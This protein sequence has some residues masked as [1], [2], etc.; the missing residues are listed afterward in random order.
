M[1]VE[2]QMERLNALTAKAQTATSEE[3]RLE[4]VTASTRKRKAELEQQSND[5]F[6]CNT[7]DLGELGVELKGVGDKELDTAEAV[8]SVGRS[9]ETAVDTSTG[10]VESSVDEDGLL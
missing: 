9:V 1:Q 6:D 7:A 10:T 4:G 2:Q 5:K 3:S 8:L